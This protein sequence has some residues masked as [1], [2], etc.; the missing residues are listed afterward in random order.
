MLFSYVSVA[1]YF[2][3]REF[4]IPNWLC[5]VG[6]MNGFCYHLLVDR[7][8]EFPNYIAGTFM[9]II[10]LFVLF[11]FQM[12]GAGDIKLFAVVGSFLGKDVVWIILYS[13]FINGIAAF[14][15]LY[16]KKA[17]K[18]RFQY[19]GIYMRDFFFNRGDFCKKRE[20]YLGENWRESPFILHFSFGIWFAVLLYYTKKWIG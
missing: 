6:I 5:A 2:D 16:K 8:L 9:P 1:M 3:K 7:L 17:F 13:M 18:E 19:F 14:S 15:I 11:Y 12:L 10:A 20:A 4:K